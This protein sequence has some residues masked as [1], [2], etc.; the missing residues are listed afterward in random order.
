MAAGIPIVLRSND[1]AQ[2]LLL[3]NDCG[4]VVGY[5]LDSIVDALRKLIEDPQL[6]ARY[7]ANGRRMFEQRYN[8]AIESQRLLRAYDIMF[9][10]KSDEPRS[11]RRSAQ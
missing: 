9:D 11:Y 7:G 6:R 1:H 4:L 5:A 8:W 3:D 2:Q 10:N